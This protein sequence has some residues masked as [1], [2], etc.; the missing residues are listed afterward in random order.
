MTGAGRKIDVG[1]R[2]MTVKRTHEQLMTALEAYKRSKPSDRP[3]M[4]GSTFLNQRFVDFEDMAEE[5][6]HQKLARSGPRDPVTDFDRKQAGDNWAHHIML[7]ADGQRAC[8]DGY[9]RELFVWATKNPN[10]RPTATTHEFCRSGEASF[11]RH[12]ETLAKGVVMVDGEPV[13]DPV[14]IRLANLLADAM[15]DRNRTLTERYGAIGEE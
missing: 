3:W 13:D 1:G 11:Q 8:R 7:S 2:K 5:S 10:T 12:L 6:M 14:I 9:A 4:N 15:L